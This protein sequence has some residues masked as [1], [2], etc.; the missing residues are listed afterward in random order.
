M[1]S[2]SPK[3]Y[4]D[5]DSLGNITHIEHIQ[6]PYL[7]ASLGEPT[8]EQLAD[9][10]VAAVTQTYKMD[11]GLVGEF[12]A[13]IPGKPTT[14]ES[15]LHRAKV[16]DVAG[17]IVVD[18]TQSFRGLPVWGGDFAVHIAPDPMRVTSSTS[19]VHNEI[20]LGNDPKK[21]ANQYKKILTAASISNFLGAEPGK[22][23]SKLNR[24][25]LMIYQYDPLQRIAPGSDQ[26]DPE[27]VSFESKPPLPKLPPVP[28][29]FTPGLHYAVVEVLFDMD[30][31][32]WKALHWRALIE[33]ISGTVLYLR[34]LVASV[35]GSIFRVDPISLSGDVNLVPSAAEA[36]LHNQASHNIAITE[37]N[38]ANPQALS[39]TLVNIQEIESPTMASPT[40]PPPHD[41]NY[42]V[43]T[44]NFAAISAYFHV[45][46]FLNLISGMGFNLGSYFDGTTFPV[47][48]DHW[49]FGGDRN[50]HCPGNVTGDGIGHFCFGTAQVGQTVGIA[51][52][53][54]VVIHEFGHGLLWDHVNSPNFGFAHSAGDALAAI[55]MDPISIAPD[56]YLTFP[57]PYPN[58]NRRHDRQVSAGWG[59]FG[60]LYD[61]QY[62][63]EQTLSTT[64][65]RLYLSAGGDSPYPADRAWASR[66]V[67][68]LIIKAIGTLT[69][70]TNIP[71]VF[72]TALMN[73]DLTTTNFEG[74]PG[75]A[76]H[77]VIRWAF[78]KQGL[79]QP[80]AHP[81]TT[82][83]V[84]QE[85]NPPDVD[86]YIDDGRHGE[87]QYQFAF[88]ESQD[89]WVR[90]SPDGG[91]THQAP[92]IGVPNYMY[93]RV[94][95]RG[96]QTA[97]NVTV[98]A[99]HCNPGTGL[100]WP[101]HWSPM[102]TPI[103]SAPSPITSNGEVI[104]GPFA[105]TPEVYGHE[106]LL[107]IASAT[108]DSGNDTTVT[109]SLPHSRFVPF[110]NNIGQRNVCPV[111]AIS[112]VKALEYLRK[113]P[114]H[115][116]NPFEKKATVEVV[117]VLPKYLQDQKYWIFFNNPG[118]NKFEIAPFEAKKITFKLAQMPK[119]PPR[120]PW[121]PLPVIP[122]PGIRTP[123]ELLGEDD[124]NSLEEA[125]EIGRPVK[126]QIVTLING[127]NMGGMTY[128]LNTTTGGLPVG[129][130]EEEQIEK[131]AADIT[132]IRDLLDKQPG[133]KNTRVRGVILE[134]DLEE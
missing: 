23:V 14:S 32:G 113:I 37:L 73:A 22:G 54:R 88:W 53:V 52:D 39:G 107:A 89:M 61:T 11:S 7:S 20:K 47:P 6:E 91:T 64:L 49:G 19:A 128:I 124:I 111:Y 82:T 41:F 15:Q 50:A 67:S 118:G 59:W 57:W 112:W 28:A 4:V 48:V 75:G 30:I 62:N 101:N 13:E 74:H 55:L 108:G 34:A 134:I 99:Y 51:D 56:R 132:Q 16:K 123:Q 81:G 80:N 114:F 25:Q 69:A 45:N 103:L 72:V 121:Q 46:W 130:A 122:K 97:N 105:W 65:F 104:V 84:T 43:K 92:I 63:G 77:K 127:Q 35:T 85:G 76:L 94:K 129:L 12:S 42:Q 17:S 87:Y 68:Y 71:E 120:R 116:I 10:Y 24:M 100:T 36:S 131:K 29:T 2:L 90:R 18:Y 115:I 79:Y 60:N 83:K 117:A 119:I 133:V 95:N 38:I 126:V 109:G 27:D 96:T 125:I 106:C 98:K 21:V 86:V 44:A 102:D 3:K 40:T 8:P 1:F 58:L 93:V 78:E 33:P 66:Y 5:R 26:P 110:D 9:E 31:S 70:M